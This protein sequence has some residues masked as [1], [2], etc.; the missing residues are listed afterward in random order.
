MR[1]YSNETSGFVNFPINHPRLNR[2]GGGGT[3]VKLVVVDPLEDEASWAKCSG[4][5]VLDLLDETLVS[6]DRQPM[7][8][9]DL[10]AINALPTQ[11]AVIEAL[12]KSSEEQLAWMRRHFPDYDNP[13]V[14]AF[15]RALSQPY[16]ASIVLGSTGWTGYNPDTGDSWSC[17][18][19]DLSPEGKVFYESVQRLYPGCKLHLLTFLD[20]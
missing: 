3:F 8:E 6:D 2:G 7:P 14:G 13:Q 20:T 17:S 9:T 15:E 5:Q 4:A 10:D 18:F 12:E 11:D 16:L 19:E 1:R